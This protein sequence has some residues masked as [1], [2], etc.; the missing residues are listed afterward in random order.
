MPQSSFE[1]CILHPSFLINTFQSFQYQRCICE[2]LSC[3][4]WQQSQEKL[5]IQLKLVN[6]KSMGP[7]ELNTSSYR[8]FELNI[9]SF[10]P[11]FFFSIQIGFAMFELMVHTSYGVDT[12]YNLFSAIWST[13]YIAINEQAVKYN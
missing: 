9:G 1:V 3:F 12:L 2:K 8:K 4:H 5:F 11:I 6:S 7:E 13:S 10:M